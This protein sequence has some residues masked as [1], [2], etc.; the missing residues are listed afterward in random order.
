ML[1]N[2]GDSEENMPAQGIRVLYGIDHHYGGADQFGGEQQV[3][4]LAIGW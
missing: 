2:N 1:P 4:P 3:R